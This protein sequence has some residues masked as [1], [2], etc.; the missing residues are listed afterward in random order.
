MWKWSGQS[1]N[2]FGIVQLHPTTAPMS[3]IPV[4]VVPWWANNFQENLPDPPASLPVRGTGFLRVLET[5]QQPPPP[6]RGVNHAAGQKNQ[7]RIPR[8]VPKDNNRVKPQAELLLL[9]LQVKRTGWQIDKLAV[10]IPIM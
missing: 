1:R 2:M 9:S 4:K 6:H 8:T 7:R 5:H 10:A 3:G